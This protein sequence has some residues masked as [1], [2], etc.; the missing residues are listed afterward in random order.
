MIDMTDSEMSKLALLLA[1]DQDEFMRIDRGS[2]RAMHALARMWL[3]GAITDG[4]WRASGNSAL[5]TM[6]T[7]NAIQP[8]FDGE[9]AALAKRMSAYISGRI[10]AYEAEIRK[11]QGM[12]RH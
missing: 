2:D 5:L 12:S 4:L 9:L 7:L 1:E 3:V 6:T 10:A 11:I 8:E